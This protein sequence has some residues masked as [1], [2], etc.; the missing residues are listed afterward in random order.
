MPNKHYIPTPVFDTLEEVINLH[1]TIYADDNPP[2]VISQWLA[3][4]FANT[5]VTIPPFASKDYQMALN[6][7]HCYRGSADTFG[8]YRRDL[9]RFLQWS[10]FVRNKSFLN[11][12]R[13][14]IEAFIEFCLKPPKRWIGLKLCSLK[15]NQWRK[16]P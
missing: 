6:F 15:D 16:T 13:E 14:D 8:A 11:H 7:L 2:H 4:C 5:K 10:W 3:H 12:K 1:K 9:E